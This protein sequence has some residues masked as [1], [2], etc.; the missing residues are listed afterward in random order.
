MLDVSNQ[1]NYRIGNPDLKQEF[2]NNFN[3]S[4]NTFNVKNFLYINSNI[5]ADTTSNKI[6]NSSD[7]FNNTILIT[8]PQNVN[9][10]YNFAFSDTIG[11]PLKKVTSG[12]RSPRNLNQ[13]TSLRYNRDISLLYK[14]SNF[15]YTKTANQR[16]NS[17]TISRINLTS[18]PALTLVTTKPL[19]PLTSS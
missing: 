4:F 2:N 13:T 12:K 18:V 10:T 1:L 11:I 16:V 9:G 17:I 19:I 7:S 6:V 14:Q 3:L 8:R 5:T 15:N